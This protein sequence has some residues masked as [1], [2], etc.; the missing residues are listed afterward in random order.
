[1]FPKYRGGPGAG[2]GLVLLVLAV[3]VG[4]GL[5]LAPDRPEAR[6]TRLEVAQA[7]V[8]PF[9]SY[10]FDARRG[11]DVDPTV[12]PTLPPAGLAGAEP[13]VT[14]AAASALAAWAAEWA[15]GTQPAPAS[16]PQPA[17]APGVQPA[18]PPGS[19]PAPVAGDQVALDPPSQ[20]APAPSAAPSPQ[21]T[22]PTTPGVTAGD[23]ATFLQAFSAES[24][25]ASTT[26]P[27]TTS[28]PVTPAAEV[29][30]TTSSSTTTT[31]T[32][33]PARTGPTRTP[34]VEAEVVPLTNRDRSG[35]GLGSLTRS[36]CLDSIASGY[37]EQMARSGVLAHNPG[38]GPAVIGCQPGA[39]WGDNVGTSRPCDAALL[40]REWMASPS[41]RKNILTAAFRQIGVGAWTDE[42]GGCWVQVLFSS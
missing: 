18:L 26:P 10:F 34:S 23:L 41:H 30:T 17:P 4:A 37:A 6:A 42:Q 8:S 11:S 40:E 36:G 35:E 25:V 1:M 19:Q 5:L 39:S 15:P 9:E 14:S 20:P 38:A 21:Q 22:V 7:S 13:Q 32:T 24:P 16:G 29:V 2:R 28:P 31:T 12:V 27:T 3:L 33:A